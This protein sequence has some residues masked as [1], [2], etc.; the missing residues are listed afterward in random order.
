[1]RA[2]QSWR[3]LSSA[4][5]V[6]I[7]NGR[8][9]ELERSGEKGYA[10]TTARDI[11]A[12]AVTSLAAIGYHFGS[13]ES[14]MNAA[15]IEA[16]GTEIGDEFRYA[17]TAGDRDGPLVERFE[18]TW[19]RMIESFTAHR[20][21]LAAGV[22][23]LAQIQHV[24]EVR[25]FLARAQQ[26]AISETARMIESIDRTVDE[27]SARLVGSFYYTLLNGL[28]VMWLI[29]RESTP[30]GSDLAS[31]ILTIA[32][33]DGPVEEVSSGTSEGRSVG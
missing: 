24:P 28:I 23:N 13:K 2:R 17:V 22:E 27:K 12:A 14:L 3:S 10:R 7:L 8:I 25:Q 20:Q 30:S 9:S 21:L 15:L 5:G 32:G 1:M 16:S 33:D 11:A 18:A 26:E 4:W 31:A 6:S 19:N 29:D